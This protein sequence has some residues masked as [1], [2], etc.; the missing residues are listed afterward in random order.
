ML[1]AEEFEWAGAHSTLAPAVD[2][3]LSILFAW[4]QLPSKPTKCNPSATPASMMPTPVP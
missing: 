2:T 4:N 1:A 3:V